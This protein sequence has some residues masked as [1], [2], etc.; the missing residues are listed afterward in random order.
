MSYFISVVLGRFDPRWEPDGSKADPC[1]HSDPLLSETVRLSLSRRVSSGGWVILF[2]E[3]PF[4]LDLCRH[5]C[6]PSV[7]QDRP[8]AS[9]VPCAR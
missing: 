5:S 6:S 2:R 3:V 9:V 7:G 8:P 4:T 1:L